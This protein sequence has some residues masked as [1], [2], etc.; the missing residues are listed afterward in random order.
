MVDVS[1]DAEISYVL[2]ATIES[3]HD[4]ICRAR[5]DPCDSLVLCLSFKNWYPCRDS[6]P[7]T[8]FR[9]PLLYPPELQGL[10]AKLWISNDFM[11]AFGVKMALTVLFTLFSPV[12]NTSSRNAIALLYLPSI[13][14]R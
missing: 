13:I 12:G 4:W 9:K 5:K 11:S 2:H 14:W 10:E 1:D 7:G 6:N 3:Y 8:R